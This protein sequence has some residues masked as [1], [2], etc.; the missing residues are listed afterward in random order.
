MELT[1]AVPLARSKRR[2]SGGHRPPLQQ[3]SYVAS[4]L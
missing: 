2:C 4:R 1:G 3:R